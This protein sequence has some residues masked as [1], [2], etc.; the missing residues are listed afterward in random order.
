MSNGMALMT[1]RTTFALDRDTVHRLKRLATCWDV[2]QAA[3]IRRAVAMAEEQLYAGERD[4]ASI[5]ED[6]HQAG[7]GLVRED[8]ES[9]VVESAANRKT[10]RGAP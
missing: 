3:V 5:L 1:Y 6:L 10:W 8:A 7:G 9:Y 4:V 2:S